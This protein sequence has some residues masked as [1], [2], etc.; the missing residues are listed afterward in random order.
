MHYGIEL[1]HPHRQE[2]RHHLHPD[3]RDHPGGA[4]HQPAG[5]A[6]ARRV[7]RGHLQRG[8][9]H[10]GPRRSHHRGALRHHRPL[11]EH[12][13][14]QSRRKPE[15]D[16]QHLP[17]D[18]PRRRGPHPPAAGKRRSL[19]HPHAPERP[20]GQGVRRDV[21][22]PSFHRRRVPRHR[23]RPL[24][25]PVHRPREIRDGGPGRHFQHL[26]QAGAGMPAVPPPGASRR[27]AHLRR[28]DERQH[29][30][31]LHRLP[32]DERPAVAGYR[33]VEARPGQNPPTGRS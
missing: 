18:P 20:A 19:V 22:V 5:P 14:G 32:L 17:H 3:G 6:G 13:D 16:V 9:Q 2:Y 23:Q 21:R 15:P 11:H 8:G 24:P 1:R 28:D 27:A 26:A 33:P 30:G 12:R 31:F 7:G 29:L 10:G 25:E 4:R